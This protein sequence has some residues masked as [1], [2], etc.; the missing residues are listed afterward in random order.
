MTSRLGRRMKCGELVMLF[1]LA[2]TDNDD[3]GLL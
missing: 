3:E 2:N 1:E